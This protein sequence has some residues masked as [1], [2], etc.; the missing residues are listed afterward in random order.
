MAVVNADIG[1]PH[2]RYAYLFFILLGNFDCLQKHRAI[3]DQFYNECSDRKTEWPEW[4][5]ILLRPTM[6]WYKK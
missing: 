2:V 6:L 5:T 3:L 1:Y 4:A